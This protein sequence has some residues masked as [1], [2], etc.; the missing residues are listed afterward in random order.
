VIA[1]CTLAKSKSAPALGTPKYTAGESIAVVAL[2]L[3]RV[4]PPAT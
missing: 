1:D 3:T 2:Q 4:I